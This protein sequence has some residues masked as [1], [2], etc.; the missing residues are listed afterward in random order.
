MEKNGAEGARDHDRCSQCARANRAPS[1][2]KCAQKCF[3][4][5]LI[6]IPSHRPSSMDKKGERRSRRERMGGKGKVEEKGEKRRN[7]KREENEREGGTSPA[8]GR[9]PSQQETRV[10][11]VI[12]GPRAPT[13]IDS[14]AL[15]ILPCSAYPSI[16]L[17]GC[18]HSHNRL[19]IHKFKP[20]T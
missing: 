6:S 17:I 15:H 14:P 18:S 8:P 11:K 13:P 2:M 5:P 3:I 1:Q 16:P 7:K 4:F 9:Y 19:L 12:G 20:A 10:G